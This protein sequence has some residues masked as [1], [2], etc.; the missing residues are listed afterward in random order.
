MKVD[1]SKKWYILFLLL[2]SVF[3]GY[4]AR[5]SISIALPFISREFSWSIEDQ[6]AL[7]GILLGIFLLGYGVSNILFSKY[8][9]IYGSKVVLTSSILLWSF[10]LLLGAAFPTYH[11]ILLS[12]LLLGISQGVLFPVASKITSNWFSPDN[13]ALANSIYVSGGPWAVMFAPVILT[14]VIMTSSWR[15]SFVIIFL[16]GLIL[17]L[18]VVLF[19][20][21]TPR[22]IEKPSV[23]KKELDYMNILGDSN[24]QVL[25]LGYTLMSSVWWGLTL[26]LPTYLVE[27]KGLELS[28]ISYGA[29]LPY[30]GAIIGMYTGSYVSDKFGKR[31]ELI[32]LSLSTGGILIL[33]LTSSGLT[34]LY[35]VLILLVLVFF[36]GQMAPP[37]YFTILQR[38][39]EPEKMGSATGLMNGIGNGLGI[40]GPLSVGMLLMMVG[41]YE[42][43]F[44]ILGVMLIAGGVSLL[45]YDEP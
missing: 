4:L 30:I 18:P 15:F 37:I 2:I 45:F 35:I 6:G 3:V 32:L 16:T 36:T 12:R 19:L 10:S 40:F 11:M 21:D 13:R 9:D 17:V 38:E 5:M 28:Q 24:F 22:D 43:S 31:R 41:S 44:A 26:W 27:A 42:F 14:P 39:V 1:R 23:K 34:G 29:S 8:I 25:M 33:I 7:G 20:T